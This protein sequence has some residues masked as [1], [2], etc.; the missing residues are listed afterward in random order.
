MIEEIN[1]TDLPTKSFIYK[2]PKH[3]IDCDK[4]IDITWSSK[5]DKYA[6]IEFKFND[7]Y[8][9]IV[10][11]IPE[12]ATIKKNDQNYKIYNTF[13]IDVNQVNNIKVAIERKPDDIFTHIKTNLNI[14][15]M[16]DNTNSAYSYNIYNINYIHG[17]H[18][19]GARRKSHKKK[20]R[21][22]R[23]KKSVRRNRKRTRTRTRR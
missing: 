19:G 10:I 3:F 4:P 23:R 11:T 12:R 7:T 2:Y 14:N 8:D 20:T 5:D 18:R 6:L 22:H 16:V 1:L 15:V 9:K 21:R 13:E 17:L